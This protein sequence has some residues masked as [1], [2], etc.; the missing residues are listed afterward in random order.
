MVRHL[1][2]SVGSTAPVQSVERPNYIMTW[3]SSSGRGAHLE[4]SV[5]ITAPVKERRVLNDP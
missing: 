2:A 4:A 3:L 1:E 5:G